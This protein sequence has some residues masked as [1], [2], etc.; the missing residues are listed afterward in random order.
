MSADQHDATE[1]EGIAEI[2]LDVARAAGDLVLPLYQNVEVELKPD[3]SHV[4]EADRRAEEL[5]RERLG[6]HFPGA[7]ILGEEF[8]GDRRP[9]PGDQWVV[10]PVDGTTAFVLG[11][12]MFGVL[13]GLLRDGD[14][15]VGV[16]HFPALN[17]TLWAASGSGCWFRG[18]DRDP[19]R[20]ACEAVGSLGEAFVS[21]SGVQRSELDPRHEP[22]VRLRSLAAAAGRFRMGGDCVQHGLVCRGR[23]HVAVDAIMN[24]WDTAALVPCVREAGGVAAGVGGDEA[25]VVFSGSLVTAS[26]RALLEETIEQMRRPV[27]PT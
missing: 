13:L 6:R 16:A 2:A 25:G 24:P 15:V 10:D 1:L 5:I 22:E 17:E 14:P 18:G 19:Q 4:T 26:T 8:G 20:V 21:V 23:L 27:D 11:L 12:P 3:G 7:A 9:V